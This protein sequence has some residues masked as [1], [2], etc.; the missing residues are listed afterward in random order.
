MGTEDC[1][2]AGAPI[3]AADSEAFYRTLVETASEG[4]LTITEGGEVVF[5][6]AALG[7]VLGNDPDA[8]VGESILTVIPERLRGDHLDGFRDYLATG[9]RH[10]DWDGVELPALH[11]DGHEVPCLISFTEHE[12]G[13]RRLFSGIVRDI[14][15]RAAYE[16]ELEEQRALTEELI[17]AQPDVFYFFDAEGRF[18]KWNDRFREVTGY[19]D[20]EIAEMEPLDFVPEGDARLVGG[21]IRTVLET[22]SSAFPESALVTKD[23][24]RIPYEFSGSRVTDADGE[25]I[26]LAGIGRDISQRK[27]R[28]EQLEQANARLEALFQNSPDMITVHDVEG[29]LL[30]V[31]Q[32]FR[33]AL[34]YAEDELVGETVWGVDVDV[35]AE[36]AREYWRTLEADDRR[37]FEGRFR[38][39]DGSTFPVEL[40]LV[41][42][43]LDEADRFL[44][45]ARDVTDQKRYERRL[46]RQNERLDRFASIV[47]HD[48]RNP[49]TVAIG[50]LELARETGD[51]EYFD[52]VAGAHERMRE[53]I[54]DL[55]AL[56]QSGD[57]AADPGPVDLA[58]TAAEAWTTVDAD[59]ATLEIDVDGTVR[60]DEGLLRQLLENLFRNAVEHGA[61]DEPSLAGAREDAVEHGSTSPDSQTRRD[62]VDHGASDE[63]SGDGVSVRVTTADGGFAVEDD[64]SGVPA[65]EHERL[66]EPGYSTTDGGAGLGLGIVEQV[67]ELHG[68]ELAVTDGSD[69]GARFEVTGVEVD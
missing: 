29:T 31:N 5:A 17:E 36:E 34:G 45:F 52:A 54:D 59:G 66:F 18:R 49:L 26:G 37:R 2:T 24:K 14:S 7:D 63:E 62:A 9:E 53:L 30:R 6:N 19:S 33:E 55:L 38:R 46:E 41:R 13:D 10:V 32:R 8:L 20:D 25:V 15:E 35:D 58:A 60:A 50:N 28:E 57:D 69:G 3:P 47:S 64:G 44:V 22:G 27:A 51:P 68:W 43:E 16:E 21:A 40:H 1:P 11:A 48:L 23:G 67:A 12:Y 39:A 4:I 61:S 56:A 42:F 65:G